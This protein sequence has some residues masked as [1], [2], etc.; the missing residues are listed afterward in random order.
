[1]DSGFT[2]AIHGARPFGAAFGV[3]ARSCA[4]RRAPSPTGRRKGLFDPDLRLH[5]LNH[6]IAPYGIRQ[7]SQTLAGT[8]AYWPPGTVLVSVVDPGVGAARRSVVAKTGSGHYVVSKVRAGK[9]D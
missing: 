5:D 9:S 7:A 1:M 4:P 3:R 8:V 6:D 2:R